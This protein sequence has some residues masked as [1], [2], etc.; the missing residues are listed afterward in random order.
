M[1]SIELLFVA[2]FSG[3]NDVKCA[4][5]TMKIYQ[6]VDDNEDK[7]MKSLYDVWKDQNERKI[8]L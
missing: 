2:W 5:N 3:E 7:I 4:E 6:F 8:H 1:K